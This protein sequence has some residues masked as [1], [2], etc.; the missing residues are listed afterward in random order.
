MGL[1]R[2]RETRM[3]VVPEDWTPQLASAIAGALREFGSCQ[4]Q[5]KPLVA[6]DVG[7]FPW[8]GSVELSLLIADELD[9]DLILSEPGEVAA[10]TYY[11]FA[12]GLSAWQPVAELGRRMA[13]A[14]RAA[15]E[16]GRSATV[17]AFVRACAV[18]VATPAVAAV[19]ESLP[20]DPRFQV[21]V[22]HPDDGRNFWRSGSQS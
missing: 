22:M 4:L 3:A 2:R 6:V 16:S 12:V 18:A 11:N 14:Y 10:W 15:G 17:D 7:C 1:A 9:S 5:G 21:R 20:R 13:D 8:H 19:L